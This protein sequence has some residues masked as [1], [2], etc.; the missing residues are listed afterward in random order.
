VLALLK[1][2]LGRDRV[3]CAAGG[4]KIDVQYI[5][6]KQKHLKPILRR[7]VKRSWRVQ[8]WFFAAAILLPITTCLFLKKGLHT[9]VESL[10]EIQQ[11]AYVSYNRNKGHTF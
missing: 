1:I 5:K 9:T 8:F 11:I 4:D 6:K 7:I 3:G 10:E 2:C